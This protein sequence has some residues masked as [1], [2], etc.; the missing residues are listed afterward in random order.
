VLCWVR[1]KDTGDRRQRTGLSQRSGRERM[2]KQEAEEVYLAARILEATAKSDGS[3]VEAT[4]YARVTE[5]VNS[6]DCDYDEIGSLLDRIECEMTEEQKHSGGDRAVGVFRRVL[7][8][9]LENGRAG[10]V[11]ETDGAVIASLRSEFDRSR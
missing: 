3:T 2:K 6:K 9:V 10:I 5:R 8:E 4:V 1:K 7:K 11:E